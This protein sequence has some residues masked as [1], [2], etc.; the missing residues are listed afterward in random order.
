MIRRPPRST[1]TDTLFPYTPLF[2]SGHVDHKVFN[3]LFY[4][5][6]LDFVIDDWTHAGPVKYQ[7][8]AVDIRRN[9]GLD[10][11]RNNS[12]LRQSMERLCSQRVIFP[13][14]RCPTTNEPMVGTLIEDFRLDK[15]TGILEWSMAPDL[16]DSKVRRGGKEVVST[17]RFRG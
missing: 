2:R 1:L 3:C 8:R 5:A 11:Q 17:G 16:R 14:I 9:L 12:Q 10:G 15:G 4:Y 6:S 7:A 13:L